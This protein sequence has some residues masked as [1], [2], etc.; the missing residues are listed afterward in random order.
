MHVAPHA[1]YAGKKS[2]K[3]WLNP[4]FWVNQIS[5][6][7]PPH[8]PKRHLRPRATTLLESVSGSLLHQA[9]DL[10]HFLSFST[11]SW[12][13]WRRRQ[14]LPTL[15]RNRSRK[16]AALFGNQDEF[17]QAALTTCSPVIIAW[18]DN[19]NYHITNQLPTPMLQTRNKLFLRE[20]S[21]VNISNR[22]KS[23]NK[24]VPR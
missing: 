22:I 20:S 21:Q 5:S 17:P 23:F 9:H 11:D 4:K 10:S 7:A 18:V 3:A 14:S 12:R 2:I 19:A 1:W 6:I 15:A 24:S 16:N 8:L 13:S